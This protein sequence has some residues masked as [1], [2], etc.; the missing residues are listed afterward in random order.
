MPLIEL[1]ALGE[2]VSGIAVLITLIY[3]AVQI[4]EARKTLT[5]QNER[6]LTS[7]M[8]D[9]SMSVAESP[10]LARTFLAGA[11]DWQALDP[12]ERL[13]FHMLL[14]SLL[15]PLEHATIDRASGRF[16]SEILNV[17]GEGAVNILRAA[18]AKDWYETNKSL[19]TPQLQAY[20]AE[21]LPKGERTTFDV[22]KAEGPRAE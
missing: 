11:T 15:S 22:I 19:F 1:G 20:I 3:L 9:V 14:W 13:N 2:F 16:Q 8:I 10:A 12:E 17:Y 21:M 4:R 18:G 7:E 6:E 5:R